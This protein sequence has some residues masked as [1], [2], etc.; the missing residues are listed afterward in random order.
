MSAPAAGQPPLDPESYE[1]AQLGRRRWVWT[2]A[3]PGALIFRLMCRAEL[4][5]ASDQALNVN[6]TSSTEHPRGM[7]DPAVCRR[8]PARS[9]GDTA[10]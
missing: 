10:G 7:G 9:R 2:A 3:Q 6:D 5:W 1:N 8:R 4:G